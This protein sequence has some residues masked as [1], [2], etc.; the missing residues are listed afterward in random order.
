MINVTLSKTTAIVSLFLLVRTLHA[1][2]NLS[3]DNTFGNVVLPTGAPVQAIH[4]NPQAMA[5][6]YVGVVASELNMQ[7][8][9]D[10]NPA[11]LASKN[12]IVG[13][14]LLN[15][16]SHA[17]ES[18]AQ[19]RLFESGVYA[20]KGKHAFGFSSRYLL[21]PESIVTDIFGNP[22]SSA[23][24][25][26]FFTGIRYAIQLS[27]NL[28]LGA[29]LNYVHSNLINGFS[30]IQGINTKPAN[31]LSGDFGLSYR[32]TLLQV[33][34][35]NLKWNAGLSVLNLG[36]KI[37][38][39]ET[40][41]GFFLPQNLRIGSLFTLK[42][43][44]KNKQYF[45]V[46]FSY[47]ATKALVPTP[48]I[49]TFTN[50]AAI[51]VDGLDP[52]VS[53]LRGAVQ[54]FYDAPDGFSEELREIIHQFGTEARWSLVDNKLLLA[55]RGGYFNEN[56]TKGN[57]KFVSAGLGIG[58]SGFRLD[59]AHLFPTNENH[60]LKGTFFLGI[61]GRLSLN[62]GSLFRFIE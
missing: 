38:Y 22:I 43:N 4:T 59:F 2:S 54:S 37:R 3:I 20:T 44:M 58:F 16:S 32:K 6:G 50:G 24:P 21:L 1:Q 9:L 18:V 42:W 11:L 49:Y 62:E 35:F 48:P 28:S 25:F 46:D 30:S 52:N 31:A 23:T 55:L 53:P 13:F 60:P 14:Q 40:D 45:A 10:Q 27:E 5:S 41:N 57:R 17:P 34:S 39:T 36:N 56:E 19:S 61:G 26:E 8:G 12:K 51:I 15:Y 33:D 29:G 7:N 47:Q